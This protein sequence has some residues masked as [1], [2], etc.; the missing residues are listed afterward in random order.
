MKLDCTGNMR[1]AHALHS[2]GF[3]TLPCPGKNT[4]RVRHALTRVRAEPDTKSASTRD[5]VGGDA[6]PLRAKD[7]GKGRRCVREPAALISL[8]RQL[9]YGVALFPVSG[10][11]ADARLLSLDWY[12]CCSACGDHRASATRSTYRCTVATSYVTAVKATTDRDS[13]QH[14]D[15]SPACWAACR[16]WSQSRMVWS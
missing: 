13:W 2:A 3:A 4:C 8:N 6:R 9:T 1:T 5:E 10:Q 16:C 14:S 12:R 11:G 7:P 15:L